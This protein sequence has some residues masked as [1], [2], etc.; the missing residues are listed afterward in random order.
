MNLDINKVLAD[1]LAVLKG[2]VEANHDKVESV[3]KQFVLQN[4]DK[5]L[6]IAKLRLSGELSDDEA[7]SR[8][9]DQKLVLEAQFNALQVV[10]KAIAQQAANAVF[11]VIEKAVFAVI[12]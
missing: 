7:K 10:S 5:L 2:T 11:D 12:S 1:V 3:T 6:M 9:E 8:I 4:K